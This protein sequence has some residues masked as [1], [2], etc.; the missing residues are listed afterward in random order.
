MHLPLD[1][2]GLILASNYSVSLI[3]RPFCIEPVPGTQG[4]IQ[5]AAERAKEGDTL[6]V[7]RQVLHAALGWHF[8]LILGCF[9]H[10]LIGP[11][12]PESRDVSHLF[13]NVSLA[14]NPVP[15]TP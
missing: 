1:Y 10:L 3:E 2:V 13:M 9:V 4:T 12:A 8:S 11:G 15:G 6:L 7:P 5:G 14:P